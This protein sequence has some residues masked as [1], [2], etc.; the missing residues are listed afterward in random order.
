MKSDNLRKPSRVIFQHPSK[1]SIRA[2]NE[3]VAEKDQEGLQAIKRFLKI[4][5]R[6][7]R[8]NNR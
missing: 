6:P 4:I 1:A 3:L 5:A 2:I 8:K 7:R